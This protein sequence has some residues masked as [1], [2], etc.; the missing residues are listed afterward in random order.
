[1][2]NGANENNEQFELR[3]PQAIYYDDSSYTS[4]PV[5][6]GSGSEVVRDFSNIRVVRDSEPITRIQQALDVG[7]DVILCPGIYM[8]QESIIIHHA[9]QILFGIGLATL[10]AP[11][12]GTPCIRVKQNT[13]G[14]RLAGLMLEA[15]ETNFCIE[16][17]VT[18]KESSALLI[19]GDTEN[20]CDTNDVANRENP[21]AMLDIYFRVGGTSST[22]N[23]KINRNKVAV[24]TMMYIHSNYV[25]GDNLWLWRADH[26]EL[27]SNE[28]CN[29]P[30]ISPLFH[31]TESDEYCVQNG[32]VVTGND[33]TIF[34]LAVEHTQSHATIWSGE[35]GAVYFY[36]CEL[37]YDTVSAKV[38]GNEKG[39][40]N[41]IAS[42]KTNVS[43]HST[44]IDLRGYCIQPNVQEH[45]LYAPGIYSNFRNEELFAFTGITHPTNPLV[46]VINPF[47]VKL[48]NLGGIMSVVNGKGRATDRQG[49]PVRCS[50]DE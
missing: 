38:R 14:I 21:G 15:S 48:D 9:N 40:N 33:V 23:G 3:V 27:D 41:L 42:E 49:A 26:A 11:N 7:K 44:A 35:R 5:L 31:Q 4:T 29:Y 22:M 43:S 45:A 10:V 30:N 19:W 36:Q 6:E 28:N 2:R 8:L 47:V 37:P 25:I 17:G 46:K 12:D 32:L 1:M 24:D 50:H 20:N 39:S 13:P 34:G 16:N 18:S